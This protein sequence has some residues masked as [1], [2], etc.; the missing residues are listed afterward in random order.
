MADF[1]KTAW[2]PAGP[3]PHLLIP[4]DDETRSSVGRALYPILGRWTHLIKP[5]PLDNLHITLA[6]AD[7]PS[8]SIS[9][10]QWD[11]AVRHI[12]HQLLR[13]PAF[14]ISLG[15]ALVTRDGVRLDVTCQPPEG[16]EY[17]AGQAGMLMRR[18]FGFAAGDVRVKDPYTPHCS[19]AYTY[20]DTPVPGE[21]GSEL[22]KARD[23]D[24]LRM[25]RMR[26][27]VKQVLLV[28]QDTYTDP[29]P[30]DGDQWP[31]RWSRETYFPLQ[32]RAADSIAMGLDDD[33]W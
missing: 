31:Y 7:V 10:G 17:F 32:L 27:A 16:M 2:S 4:L 21:L 22:I 29:A 9:A 11:K 15:P 3:R 19:L 20:T 5:V 23:D 24:G 14:Q 6:W 8:D 12:E 33:L 25:P 13:T 26:L 18:G 1:R 30:D 28:A